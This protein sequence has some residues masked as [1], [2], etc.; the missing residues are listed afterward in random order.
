MLANWNRFKSP[1]IDFFY[2]SQ[3]GYYQ[4]QRN[5]FCWGFLSFPVATGDVDFLAHS[6]ATVLPNRGR[7]AVL[8]EEWEEKACFLEIIGVSDGRTR[9]IALKGRKQARKHCN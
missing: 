2:Q 5:R 6:F 4:L 1:R 8:A 7:S 9:V 3:G